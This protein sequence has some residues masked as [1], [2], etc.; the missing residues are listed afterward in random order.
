[1]GLATRE[2]FVRVDAIEL[3][4]EGNG[5]RALGV[6][7]ELRD[8]TRQDETHPAQESKSYVD[9]EEIDAV[10][11]AWDRVARTDDTI[12]KLNNFQSSYRTKGNLEIAV[13]RQTSGGA[14]A[15][16]V[17]GGCDQ[18]RVFLS[19]DEFIKLRWMIVQAKARLDE[20]K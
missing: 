9:Y 6:V 18:V 10:I 15:A 11:K 4:D 14:I 19:L 13:F 8:P 5:T 16:A 20:I 17:S 2:G 1:M 3:R 12:T 7:V